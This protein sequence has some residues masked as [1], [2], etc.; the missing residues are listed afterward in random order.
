MEI[1]R[2]YHRLRGTPYYK[3][4]KKALV[5]EGGGMRGIFLTGVLQSFTDRG[6]FPWKLI[7][8]SSAGAL[9]G[10][11]YAARQIHLARDAFFTE[12]LSGKFINLSNILRPE[13][14]ILNLDWM[15][16]TIIHG[17]EPLSSRALSRACPVLITATDCRPDNPPQTLYFSTRRDDMSSVLKATAAIPVLYR[18]FVEYAK[19]HLLD[20]G[21]L[22]PIP[23][24][25][26]L[27]MGYDE[28]EILVVVTRRHGYRKKEESFWIRSL[29]ESYY[30]D[31]RYRFLVE[32]ISNRY[33]LYN[34]TLDELE[35]RHRGIDVI[36]PPDDFRVD[37]LSRDG[38]KILEGF[39]QGAVA[40]RDYLR[41]LRG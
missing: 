14:H 28:D 3:K 10:T 22:D 24:A 17:D 41:R 29:Y 27:E 19:H 18:G 11:A 4:G 8:G 13:R 5:I 25:K 35:Q 16:D 34:K 38:K 30:K 2:L 39:A 23:Y 36:Y 7:I 15:V 6:Y 21:L 26:A 12:L 32:A 37:R 31:H 1:K 33:L 20:G 40:G 9:T